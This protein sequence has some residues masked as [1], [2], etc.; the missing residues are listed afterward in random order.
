MQNAELNLKG[1]TVLYGLQ[2]LAARLPELA[3]KQGRPDRFHCF[4]YSL[5][6]NRAQSRL[7]YLLIILFASQEVRI[8]RNC[9]PGLEYEVLKISEQSALRDL[10]FRTAQ[11]LEKNSKLNLWSLWYDRDEQFDQPGGFCLSWQSFCLKPVNNKVLPGLLQRYYHPSQHGY[12][13]VSG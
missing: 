12:C 13:F 3:S 7:L 11:K 6:Q 4:L 1:A 9:A 10:G 5:Q 8:G 2:P